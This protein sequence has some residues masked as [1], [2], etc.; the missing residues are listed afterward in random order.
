MQNGPVFWFQL[1]HLLIVGE[2]LNPIEAPFPGVS[3]G[4][5]STGLAALLWRLET[6]AH[7]GRKS[8]VMV[9]FVKVWVVPSKINMLNSSP[10][11]LR[12]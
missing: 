5:R 10:Q 6:C 9:E 2:T 12:M 8:P 4:D 3:D 7:E 1:H 11:Q